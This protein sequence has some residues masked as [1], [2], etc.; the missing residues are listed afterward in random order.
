MSLVRLAELTWPEAEELGKRGDAVGLIPT[1]A[2]EQHGPHLPLAT[3]SFAAGDLARAVAERL[4]VPVVVT[5]TLTA[6]LSDHHLA[7]PGTVSLSRETFGGW[8]EAHIAG[9]ERMGIRRVAVFSG[10][11]GN[12]AFIGELAE[13]YAGNGGA[14]RVIAY[15]DLMG[16]VRV[17]DEAA[18]AH[19]LEAPPTDVHAG[20]LETSL[21][22]ARFEPGLVRDYAGV[23]GYTAAE[24]G[25][26]ER[27]WTDGLAALTSS[28]VLGDPAGATAEVGHAIFEAL[29][30]E[31]AGWI[32]GEFELPL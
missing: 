10:P 4:P 23:E 25:W 15:D 22:L 9:L 8:I 26:M 28:G 30:D 27:I 18:R 19:G 13:R 16:F 31:L 3:D 17:M 5:P 32:A 12:F 6:G 24:E 21:A 20:S 29:A 11:G 7:F 2:L 1:G 14:T